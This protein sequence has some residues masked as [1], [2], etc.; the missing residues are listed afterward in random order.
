M[1]RASCAA[2][3]TGWWYVF[4]GQPVAGGARSDRAAG[5]R[6]GGAGAETIDECAAGARG[7]E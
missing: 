4:P 3:A 2:A 6:A 1:G 5:V 7:T